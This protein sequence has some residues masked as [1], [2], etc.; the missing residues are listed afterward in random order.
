MEGVRG[1]RVGR[2]RDSIPFAGGTRN[3]TNGFELECTKVHRE[4]SN[5]VPFVRAL[6][7]K[8]S[9]VQTQRIGIICK[10]DSAR[11]CPVYFHVTRIA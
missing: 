9:K 6:E 8:Y 2:A 7:I 3:L 4:I 5:C 11:D 1:S 10:F